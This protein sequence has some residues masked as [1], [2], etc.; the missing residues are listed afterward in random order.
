MA[1]NAAAAAAAQ[2]VQLGYRTLAGIGLLDASPVYQ[3]PAN[4]EGPTGNFR[5]CSFSRNGQY[6]AYASPERVHIAE[7]APVAQGRVRFI[8]PA[9]NVYEL[10]FSPSGSYAMLWQRP[11][12]DEN[13]DSVPNLTI[14]KLKQPGQEQQEQPPGGDGDGPTELDHSAR[15]AGFVQK[16][17]NGW[18][19]QFDADETSFVRLVNGA[20]RIFDMASPQSSN[21][22]LNADDVTD[23]LVEPHG[24]SIATFTPA[25]KGRPAVAMLFIRDKFDPAMKRTFFKGDKVQFKWAPKGNSLIVL[26]QTDVDKS[27]MN[28]YGEMNLYLLSPDTSVQ[29]Q[30]DKQGPIHDVSWS[31]SG[32]EFAVVYGYIPAKTTIFNRNGTATH[33]FALGPKNTALFSPD[34]RFLL[35]AG[36]GNLQGGTDMY[37]LHK[38]FAKIASFTAENATLCEWAPDSTHVLTATTSPRLRVDNGVRIYHVLG[39]LV[40]KED[41]TELYWAGWNPGLGKEAT[42]PQPATGTIPGPV[43]HASATAYLS[44][45]KTPSKPVGAYRPPGA[46]GLAASL[47]YKR[48]DEGGAAFVSNGNGNGGN[49][50]AAGGGGG[51]GGAGAAFGK[52]RRREVP[53]AES[54]DADSLAAPGGGVFLPPEEG[55]SKTALKNKKKREA[56]K[57]KEMAGGGGEG[58]KGAAVMDGGGEGGGGGSGHAA[59]GAGPAGERKVNG[60]GGLRP[61]KGPRGWSPSPERRGGQMGHRR[62]RSQGGDARGGYGGSS[63]GGRGRERKDTNSAVSQPTPAAPA[64]TPPPAAPQLPPVA[65]AAAA[66]APPAATASSSAEAQAQADAAAGLGPTDKKLRSLHKKMRAIEE[67]KMRQARGEKLEDTQVKKIATEEEIRKQLAEMGVQDA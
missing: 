53:G 34:G 55:L 44:S 58:E 50:G 25:I 47:S 39:M 7:T 31:P 22:K 30:L 21:K 26:A 54:A 2:P 29:I 51:G 38:D 35:L 46:R 32:R 23:F 42:G 24:G 40:Y 61:P 16:S 18:V 13:G 14:W 45:V 56:K 52:P 3:R 62:G 66:A 15:V 37:D 8:I 43:P 6:F 19:P 4:F 20:V 27:N 12:K 5:C 49:G 33:D 10:D 17:Q 11:S 64:A 36:F 59:A 1:A 41:M 60:T 63:G 28:Y 48:E 67:L 57:A 9:A 65:A